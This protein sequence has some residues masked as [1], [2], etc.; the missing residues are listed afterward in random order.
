MANHQEGTTRSVAAA[1][2]KTF[3]GVI[4]PVRRQQ[5]Q[6]EQEDHQQEQKPQKQERK[7][8]HQQI[9]QE[10][11]Q[12]QRPRAI[13][14]RSTVPAT[15]PATTPLTASSTTAHIEAH[16]LDAQQ[17]L[18]ERCQ[19]GNA[20]HL[21]P[22]VYAWKDAAEKANNTPYYIDLEN[23]KT[24]SHF[25]TA[26]MPPP[27]I[28]LPPSFPPPI[29]AATNTAITTRIRVGLFTTCSE[30]WVGKDRETWLKMDM[31]AWVA[32]VLPGRPQGRALVIW[33][34]DAPLRRAR[35]EASS[36]RIKNV[37]LGRQVALVKHLLGKKWS[38]SQGVW[39]GGPGNPTAEKCLPLA[40]DWVR[41]TLL[42]LGTV[43]VEDLPELGFERLEN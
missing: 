23:R 16:L 10:H 1:A 41:N 2:K 13:T 3:V 22:D 4:V 31:H 25:S 11:Q 18:V 35:Q 9:K 15:T 14:T 26:P 19:P 28:P 33:D 34:S 24:F 38:L 36:G 30:T 17:C 20:F 32:F 40:M 42:P 12:R 6:E 37:L 8:K 5:Q 21:L 7:Q 27:S 39:Y 29:A 43:G